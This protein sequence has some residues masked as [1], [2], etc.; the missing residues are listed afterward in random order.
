MEVFTVRNVNEAMAT[1]LPW[2]LKEGVI[3]NSRNGRVLVAPTPVTTVYLKPQ[4]RVLF[5]TARNANPFFHTMEALWM[6]AGRNDLAFPQYF[7]KRFGE[8]S[9]DGETVHG[10]YGYRWRKSLG[11]DQLKLIA[12]ELQKNPNSR[13]CVLQM[14]DGQINKHDG[15]DL[16]KAMNGGKDVPCNTHA[17]FDAR[18]GVLNMTVC[19]RSNDAIW[20]AYGANAVH[21]SVL[22]EYMA[23]W[24]GIPVGVYRQVSNN[25][26]AYLDIYDETAL[27]KM[28]MESWE[29]KDLYVDGQVK[30]QS[31]ID[32]RET[33]EDFN[34]DLKNFFK[35]IDTNGEAGKYV[36]K[37]EFF[38]KTVMKM[39]VAWVKRKEKTSNGL[40]RASQIAATDWRHAC[41]EWIE[42]MEAKK[43]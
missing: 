36:F 25:F 13:R 3:E 8:Y 43:L 27:A 35:D 19:N 21:F 37:T 33:I 18:G 17:Y 42:R 6:L 38:R 11:Y 15:E 9:D 26:H 31:L 4:E 7:N 5:S 30:P 28:A 34:M 22:Q 12:E 32:S 39:Y 14:W 24:V 16:H 23:A 41:I 29:S 20:G 2:L 1:V 40:E 10:A